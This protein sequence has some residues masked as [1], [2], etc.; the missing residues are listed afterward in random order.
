MVMMCL[1]ARCSSFSVQTAIRECAGPAWR[2]EDGLQ[3]PVSTASMRSPPQKNANMTKMNASKRRWK[4]QGKVGKNGQNRPE[5]S[6][7]PPKSASKSTPLALHHEVSVPEATASIPLLHS[8]PSL[9]HSNP[10]VPA[11]QGRQSCACM[12]SAAAPS[13]AAL[14]HPGLA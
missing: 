9:A 6:A 2:R 1:F 3:H 10:Q 4:T 5:T 11:S 13:L 14:L 12:R 7:P 8:L